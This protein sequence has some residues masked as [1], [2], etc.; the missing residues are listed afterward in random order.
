MGGGEFDANAT[1]AKKV[2]LSNQV[3][4][5]EVQQNPLVFRKNQFDARRR[6]GNIAILQILIPRN[7]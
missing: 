7:P 3:S 5:T 1:F 2:T 6:R 4:M